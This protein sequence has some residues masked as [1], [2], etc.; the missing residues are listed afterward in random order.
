MQTLTLRPELNGVQGLS[1]KEKVMMNLASAS[2]SANAAAAKQKPLQNTNGAI[3]SRVVENQDVVKT[4]GPDVA[5]PRTVVEATSIYA[6]S[7]TDTTKNATAV[8][9][10]STSTHTISITL[11]ES[12]VSESTHEKETGGS[13][14]METVEASP[15]VDDNVTRF[16]TLNEDREDSPNEGKEEKHTQQYLCPGDDD[17]EVD[18]TRSRTNSAVDEEL[19]LLS[20]PPNGLLNLGNT[21]YLNSALQMLYSLE[22]GFVQDLLF[23]SS[24]TSN[25]N[26]GTNKTQIRDAMVKIGKQMRTKNNQVV[27]P[28]PIKSAV[29]DKMDQFIGNRQHDS[30]EFLSTL[31]DLLHEELKVKFDVDDTTKSPHKDAVKKSAKKRKKKKGWRQF[32]PFSGKRVSSYSQFDTNAISDL[33]HNNGSATDTPDAMEEEQPQADSSP[34]TWASIV[35]SVS[36]TTDKHLTLM[37]GRA[38]MPVEANSLILAPEAKSENQE[39]NTTVMENDTTPDEAEDRIADNNTS[40]ENNIE[41]KEKD[42]VEEEDVSSQQESSIV[43]AHFCTEIRVTLTCDSCS[44]MRSKREMYRYLSIEVGSDS[45]KD[46]TT[47]PRASV[48]EGIRRFFAPEKRELKCEKCF[49]E[50]ATQTMKVIRLPNALLLHLKRFIVEWDSE[51][52]SVSYTK[53]QTLVEY[54][55]TLN[56]AENCDLDVTLPSGTNSR[57]CCVAQSSVEDVLNDDDSLSSCSMD[58]TPKYSL[59]SVVHHIG[60][61]TL[62]GHYT[63]DVLSRKY[64]NNINEDI[65]SVKWLRCNDSSVTAYKESDAV[66]KVEEFQKTAYMVMYELEL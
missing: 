30:H 13:E 43:D 35:S 49:F 8:V 64:S 32:V 57:L 33:L 66:I 9:C 61:S 37:G 34:T 10:E 21:C 27:D 47:P 2:A 55:E 52:G 17:M 25:N 39:T 60:S 45:D 59:K 16:V 62:C 12:V 51:I 6:G 38:A 58:E 44:F 20:T 29:D 5:T 31:L 50:T 15:V 41:I 3:K 7:F 1:E 14:P 56:L 36:P 23:K 63:A 22:N 18:I 24:H 42:S 11:P 65:D 48:E 40:M 19:S 54:G 46:S 53:N 4:E 26:N 28:T